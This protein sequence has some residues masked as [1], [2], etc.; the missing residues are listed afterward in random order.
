MAGTPAHGNLQGKSIH[1]T[2]FSPE[3]NPP[4]PTLQI[5]NSKLSSDI[6][7]VPPLD[8]TDGLRVCSFSMAGG[9]PKRNSTQG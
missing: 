3:Y 5:P 4:P 9:L 1:D 8:A 6:S 7:P 2:T